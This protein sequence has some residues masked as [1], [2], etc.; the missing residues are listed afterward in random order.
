DVRM[1]GSIDGLGLARR[2]RAEWP[3]LPVVIASAHWQDDGEQLADRQVAK[4]YTAEQILKIAQ[5]L[6]E[7][8]WPTKLSRCQAS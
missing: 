2:L 1:P 7:N 4:P 5:E 3:G 6:V 8:R